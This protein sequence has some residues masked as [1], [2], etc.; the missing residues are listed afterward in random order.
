MRKAPLVVVAIL[1]MAMSSQVL[2]DGFILVDE[3][4]CTKVTA[5]DYDSERGYVNAIG[6]LKVHFGEVELHT[7]SPLGEAKLYEASPVFVAKPA[8]LAP[9]PQLGSAFTAVGMAQSPPWVG[10]PA[11][12]A[13]PPAE[14]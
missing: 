9:V 1:F 14:R 10:T 7:F 12:S 2:A 8:L 13:G 4:R 11:V 3:K 6:E 5:S